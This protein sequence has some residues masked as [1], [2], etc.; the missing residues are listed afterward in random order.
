MTAIQ[1]GPK[2]LALMMDVDRCIGCHACTVACQNEHHDPREVKRIRVPTVGSGHH[3]IPA[4]TYPNV[5]MYFQPRMCQHCTDAPCILSC[6]FD[7]IHKG[8]D[9]VVRIVDADCTGCWACVPACPYDVISVND[10]ERVVA[11]CDLCSDRLAAGLRPACVGACPGDALFF[12]DVLD[13]DSDL[14]VQRRRVPKHDYVLAGGGGLGDRPSAL[15]QSRKP[16][17][18]EDHTL[19]PAA[20]G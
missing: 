9:G 13:V 3:D 1:A 8:P 18:A 17:R 4:G 11:I 15:Y 16:L 10:D 6:P 19:A 12:G 5:W 20:G 2:Q 14:N 7:A